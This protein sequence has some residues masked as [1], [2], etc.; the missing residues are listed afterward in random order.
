MLNKNLFFDTSGNY[1]STK[2]SLWNLRLQVKALD[3]SIRRIDCYSIFK[4]ILADLKIH[5]RNKLSWS[6]TYRFS[7]S[8]PTS[9]HSLWKVSLNS[10]FS[11]Y[12]LFWT[13]TTCQILPMNPWE[14]PHHDWLHKWLSILE[15]CH[16][17]TEATLLPGLQICEK[18]AFIIVCTVHVRYGIK[19]ELNHAFFCTTYFE[20]INNN[21][22][23]VCRG[24]I[25]IQ[26]L[27]SFTLCMFTAIQFVAAVYSIDIN[28]L[29]HH[30]ETK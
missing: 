30:T 11:I 26:M 27:L 6:P 13:S 16:V 18:N 20:D 8:H 9:S 24:P 7:L 23:M 21:L 2:G 28:V 22:L 3:I 4:I 25:N 14:L 29:L 12:C 5:L 1:G 17:V 10:L 15:Q 19:Q